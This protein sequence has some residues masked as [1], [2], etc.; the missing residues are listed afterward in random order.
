MAI[1]I[2]EILPYAKKSGSD[3]RNLGRWSWYLLEGSP[4][5]RTHGVSAYQV[6]KSEAKRFGRVYQQHLRYIQHK[7]LDTTPRDLFREDL[8]A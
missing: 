6:G 1:N 4:T 2:N 3:F 7:G 5:H 8:L